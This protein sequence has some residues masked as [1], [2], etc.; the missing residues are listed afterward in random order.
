MK[1]HGV[2]FSTT[3]ANDKFAGS[4]AGELLKEQDWTVKGSASGE[5]KPAKKE[6]KATGAAQITSPDFSGVKSFV[7]VSTTHS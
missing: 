5:Y 2:N 6:H 1:A 3:F 4:A 7:N